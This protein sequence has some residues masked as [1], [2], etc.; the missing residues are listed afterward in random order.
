MNKILYLESKEQIDLFCRHGIK[1]VILAPRECSQLGRLSWIEAESLAILAREK[2]LKPILEWDLLM[3]EFV[4]QK[5]IDFLAT[6]NFSVWHSIRLLDPGAIQWSYQNLSLPLQIIAEKGFHNHYGLMRLKNQLGS[7]LERFILSYEIPYFKMSA[8]IEK[9]AVP[10]ELLTVGKILLFHSP[11]QLLTTDQASGD[12]P[13]R[14]W[15]DAPDSAHKKFMVEENEHGT[16]LFHRKH[17]YLHSYQKELDLSGIA[18]ARWDLREMTFVQ[19]E[20]FLADSSVYPFESFVGL[21]LQNRTDILFSKLKNRFLVPQD[22]D[23]LGEVIHV[24]KDQ[25]LV[26][27]CQ[28]SHLLEKA[29]EEHHLLW[30]YYTPQGKVVKVMNKPWQALGERS[31][32]YVR[33]SYIKGI[34]PKTVVY[35]RYKEC[36]E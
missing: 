19:Q 15:A 5:V 22:E 4:F 30:E 2:G 33:T 32:K 36:F 1:E 8:I 11:R 31:K 7:R 18:C 20:T 3:T 26:I 21:F 23:F 34:V 13:K 25:C 12:Q 16:F 28:R 35:L 27:Q 17:L 10:C 14:M 9:I 24:E 6:K 29:T